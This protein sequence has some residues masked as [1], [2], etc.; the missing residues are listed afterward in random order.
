MTVAIAA[1]PAP[2][3]KPKINTGSRIIFTMEPVTEPII[4][5]VAC[6]SV[7]SRF[8]GAKDK[9]TNGEPKAIQK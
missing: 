7:R 5:A 1:P 9:I 6:P 3:C 4:A 8:V 2:I